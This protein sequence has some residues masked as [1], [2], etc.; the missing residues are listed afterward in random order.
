MFVR[1]E[2]VRESTDLFISST[3]CV[4]SMPPSFE[5]G[6]CFHS[7]CMPINTLITRKEW[8]FVFKI[9]STH[10]LEKRVEVC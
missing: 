5:V 1:F 3:Q 2:V 10:P 8:Y 4:L 7:L 9:V 6:C